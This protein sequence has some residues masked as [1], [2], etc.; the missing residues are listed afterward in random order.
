MTAC[1]SS[2]GS[3]TSTLFLAVAPLACSSPDTRID[4]AT[5]RPMAQRTQVQMSVNVLS[6]KERR[7]AE[8]K[9]RRAK[10]AKQKRP[11]T[12][13]PSKTATLSTFQGIVKAQANAKDVVV[14]QL[15]MAYDG[16]TT[17]QGSNVDLFVNDVVVEA[18]K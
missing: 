15:S 10:K 7:K 4:P 6:G 16:K 14:D 1:S 17:N 13:P 12:A 9:A 11:A 18:E 8:K 5:G 3:A 2:S